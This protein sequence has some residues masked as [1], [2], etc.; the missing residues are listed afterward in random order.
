MEADKPM[1]IGLDVKSLSNQRDVPIR[2]RHRH[3]YLV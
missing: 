1:G 3:R 2:K